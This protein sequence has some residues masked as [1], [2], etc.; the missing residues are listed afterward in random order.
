M[1]LFS[2]E[3]R[4][5]RQCSFQDRSCVALT[6]KEVDLIIKF[7]PQLNPCHAA[8]P[9]H[10][11]DAG[12]R[13]HI[14]IDHSH[15]A[16]SNQCGAETH[17]QSVYTYP[18]ATYKKE[19][20]QK[21]IWHLDKPCSKLLSWKKNREMV[22]SS[23][24][25][26]SSAEPS[27]SSSSTSNSSGTWDIFGVTVKYVGF[28]QFTNGIMSNQLYSTYLYLHT[29]TPKVKLELVS[30]QWSYFWTVGGRRKTRRPHSD[31]SPDWDSNPGPSW[32]PFQVFV[33]I[34][35]QIENDNY[36]PSLFEKMKLQK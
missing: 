11:L 10:K 28:K 15:S 24:S 21:L 13:A 25:C 7:F 6:Y 27:F 32:F 8:G 33:S 20:P 23:L 9:T 14:D 5:R 29:H 17:A 30:I 12:E 18:P 36:T 31:R 4:Y 19:K 22:L 16:T 35:L 3:P 2:M 1:L 26:Y 34:I